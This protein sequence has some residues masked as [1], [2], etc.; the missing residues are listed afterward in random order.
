MT[1]IL[2][3]LW[4]L[5]VGHVVSDFFLQT[6]FMAHAKCPGCEEPEC[7]AVDRTKCGPWWLW[8]GAHG[9]LNGWVTSLVLGVWWV[10]PIEA[11]HH[12]LIDWGKCMGHVGF[13]ADQAHHAYM[14]L[15]LLYIT[16]YVI[17]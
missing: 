17:H 4:L 2:R 3:L 5:A 15:L 7:E 6:E 12:A 16:V 14:K 1:E 9:M 13:W 10:G 8:M 11:A